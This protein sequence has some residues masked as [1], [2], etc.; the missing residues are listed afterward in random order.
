MTS[1]ARPL[2]AAAV[3]TAVPPAAPAA[4][5]DEAA[6][7]FEASVRPILVA[8]CVKCH[9]PEKQKGGLRLDSGEAALKGGDAGP[10][11][12]PGKPDASPLIHAVRYGDVQMPPAGKM[13][14]AEIAALEKWVKD[15]AVWP[16]AKAGGMVPAGHAARKPGTIT[17]EDRAWWAFRPVAPVAVPGTRHPARN[18]VDGFVFARLEKEGLSPAPEA[19]KLALLRRVTFDLTGLPP[20]PDE[21]AAFLADTSADAYEK[22]VDRLLASPRY[23]ERQARFWL[24]LVRYAESD[25]YRADF[26][27]PQAWRYRD[28]VVRSFAADKPFDRFVRE[29]LAGDELYPA[30]PDALIATGFLRLG[31]YEYNQRDV[32]GQWAAILNDLTDVTGDALLGLGV[33]CARCHDHKFDPLLQKDYFALQS[34]FAGIAMRDEPVFASPAAKAEYDSKLAAWEAKTAEVRAKIDALLE[35]IRKKEMAVAA[36][37]FPADIQPIFAKAPADRTPGE[38]QLYD[39]AYRQVEYEFDRAPAKLKGE[40][41]AEYDR[42]KKELDAVAKPADPDAM[43][44]RDLGPVA[45]ETRMGGGRQKPVTVDPAFPTVL[46]GPLPT[47]KGGE[48]TT[49]RRAALAEWLTRPDHPLTARVLVNRVWQ[50]HFGTGLVATPSDYGTLGEKPT[51]PEL[52]DHLAAE[53]VRGGWKLKPLHRLIVTSA[54]YRQSSAV[55]ATSAAK[56]DPD[57]R[58]LW[59]MTVRRLDAEQVRDAL[60]ATSGELKLDAGG[61]SV[62]AGEPRRSVFTKV[63]RNTPDPLLASFDAADGI[64]GCAKR[65]VTVTPTQSLLLLNGGFGLARAKAFATRVMPADGKD[66]PE[67]V[68]KAFGLAFGRPPTAVEAEEALAFLKG[69]VKVASGNG[70]VTA[71]H[72][73]GAW[74][75]FCHA[76][77][78]ANEFLYVD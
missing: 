35:P 34:F 49:G 5:K 56:N 20:T 61:P 17:D 68:R 67:G 74:T 14:D 43:V 27:R 52:L 37:K 2:L 53:F 13:S 50:Q 24:D 41:K 40:Q 72:R 32:R 39:L 16:G 4:D 11:V 58:L 1:Y 47:I 6:K 19:G 25:G 9:G 26:P 59:R 3:L 21:V 60:L 76:L 55:P 64:L 66:A 42:L 22:L 31:I 18:A 48:Q 77:L 73:L 45:A 62:P 46:G 51:H 7:F 23:A 15:G 33:G 30:D 71:A 63:I 75:D 10:A 44:T 69:Q 65:N 57:A 8:Q 12:V 70:P 28:Y 78:N 36:G 29:Q 38:R 54:T